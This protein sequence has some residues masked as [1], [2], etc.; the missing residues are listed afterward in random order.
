MDNLIEKI[1]FNSPVIKE[2][3]FGAIPLGNHRVVIELFYNEKNDN[4]YIDVSMYDKRNGEEKL[5]YAYSIT[6]D[7]HEGTKNIYGY[8]GAMTSPKEANDLLVK[9][10]WNIDEL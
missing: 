6:Y 4:L 7:Y 10:G 1:E 2:G 8:E 3:S 9:H 5:A